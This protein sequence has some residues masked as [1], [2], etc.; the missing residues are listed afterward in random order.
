MSIIGVAKYLEGRKGR[1]A[2]EERYGMPLKEHQIRQQMA[3]AKQQAEREQGL[4]APGREEEAALI[5]GTRAYT[6]PEQKPGLQRQRLQ[7]QLEGEKKRLA[8]YETPAETRLAMGFETPAQ[9]RAATGYETP[10]QQRTAEQDW[11]KRM[12]TLGQQYALELAGLKGKGT[13]EEVVPFDESGFNT[14]IFA[15]IAGTLFPNYSFRD[16]HDNIGL[17]EVRKRI[18]FEAIAN[19]GQNDPVKVKQI[20]ASLDEWLRI[21]FQTAE[22]LPEEE[23]NQSFGEVLSK[24]GKFLVTPL[25]SERGLT[26]REISKIPKLEEEGP[27]PGLDLTLPG[28][29][30]KELIS[31]KQGLSSEKMGGLFPGL[32]AVN[33]RK[34]RSKMTPG[35]M[36]G[37]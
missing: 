16:V 18:R 7:T 21:L 17:E 8:G 26:R 3:I 23:K 11:E 28:A 12:A 19:Y 24:I 35:I 33:K 27:L 25:G 9:T 36:T 1:K 14:Q 37:H 2:E 32:S 15:N 5:G 29:E 31:I 22:T 10:G 13:E 20:E 6:I 4:W 30:Q 34:Y